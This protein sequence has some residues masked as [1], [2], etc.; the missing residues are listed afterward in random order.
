MHLVAQISPCLA[1]SSAVVPFSADGHRK[2]ISPALSDT[3]VDVIRLLK[4]MCY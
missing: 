3:L 1:V 4:K 2:P